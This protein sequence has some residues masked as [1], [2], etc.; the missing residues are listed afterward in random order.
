MTPGL[1]RKRS[2]CPVTASASRNAGSSRAASERSHT[3]P[4]TVATGKRL[5]RLPPVVEQPVAEQDLARGIAQSRSASSRALPDPRVV[6]HERPVG[7]RSEEPARNQA[8][9]LV[10]AGV[11]LRVDR[12][13]PLKELVPVH[14]AADQPRPV[15][16]KSV[17]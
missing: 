8:V 4:F 5:R 7:R 3:T 1:K 14:V 9:G 15:D 16:R 11:E 12:R 17:V 13:L 2:Q 6:P 10:L